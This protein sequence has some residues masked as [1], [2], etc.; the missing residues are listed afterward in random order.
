MLNESLFAAQTV[1]VVLVCWFCRQ[2]GSGALSSWLSVQ[3]LLA[4][5]LVLKLVHLFNL[6]VTVADCFGIGAIFTLN[7][8]RE[9]HGPDAA[10][11]AMVTSVFLMM[12]TAWFFTLHECFQVSNADT[13]AEVYSALLVNI[14]PIILVSATVFLI[15]QIID[16]ILFGYLQSRFGHYSLGLRML[17]SMG[18]SQ[19]VDTSLFTYW[20]LGNWAPDF[21]QVFVWSYGLKV[22]IM[23]VLAMS[24]HLKTWSLK[25]DGF[26]Q[27]VQI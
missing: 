3:A 9:Y 25:K 19:L 24:T 4:N 22:M 12:A 21:F 8:L 13:L 15:V 14:T 20:A 1:S 10:K 23:L 27:Y 6:E 11:R 26:M 7:L 2:L 17:L 16:Y 18:L 5:L